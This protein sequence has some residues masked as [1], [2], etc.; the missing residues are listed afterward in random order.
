MSAGV[1]A[2]SPELAFF[3]S[4]R[5][6]FS[7]EFVELVRLILLSL[8]S[9]RL[10]EWGDVL[11]DRFGGEDKLEDKLNNESKDELGDEMD[12]K[13]ADRFV[14]E[15]SGLGGGSDELLGDA[16]A[17]ESDDKFAENLPFWL[18]SAERLNNRTSNA[19]EIGTSIFDGALIFR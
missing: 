14:E 11:G 8:A 6:K 13:R 12:D 1:L 4:P 17:N 9:L 10:S 15:F 18:A 2:G 19:N 7:V 16:L 3:A 5:N